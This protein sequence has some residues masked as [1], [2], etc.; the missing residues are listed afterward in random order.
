MQSCLTVALR[1][2]H[3]EASANVVLELRLRNVPHANRSRI[4]LG[5]FERRVNELRRRV[6]HQH[7]ADALAERAHHLRRPG[8]AWLQSHN[9]TFA[10]RG[11]C[12]TTQT[13]KDGKFV[14]FSAY[15]LPVRLPAAEMRHVRAGRDVR[16]SSAKPAPLQWLECRQDGVAGAWVVDVAPTDDVVCLDLELKT[17]AAAKK[18]KTK[19]KNK[20]Q[21]TRGRSKCQFITRETT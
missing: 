7:V 4:L 13:S 9:H 2:R 14:A 21:L 1:T 12:S 3:V 16:P 19:T 6:G 10:I 5:L 20:N 15:R 11:G 8:T 18:Q 17:H